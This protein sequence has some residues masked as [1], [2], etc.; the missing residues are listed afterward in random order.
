M[1]SMKGWSR[2]DVLAYFNLIGV[3][4]TINGEGYVV[5]QS[6]GSG[7]TINLDSE[8]VVELQDKF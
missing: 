8:I 7:T 3:K 4:C 2:T 6:I 1:P 5:S